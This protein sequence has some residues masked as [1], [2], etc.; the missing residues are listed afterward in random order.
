MARKV[1]GLWGCI[2]V[3]PCTFVPCVGAGAGTGAG[4]FV[5]GV[6][7]PCANDTCDRLNLRIGMVAGMVVDADAILDG[8]DDVMYRFENEFK[9]TVVGT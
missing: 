1:A 8:D 2:V 4:V 9:G 5:P 7:V 6:F 3:N